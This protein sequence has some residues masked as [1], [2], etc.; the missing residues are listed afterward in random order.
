MH[1]QD[2]HSAVLKNSSEISEINR[3]LRMQQRALEAFK[4]VSVGSDELATSSVV[5]REQLCE[6]IEAQQARQKELYSELFDLRKKCNHE[7]VTS[8]D[9]GFFHQVCSVCNETKSH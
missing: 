7:F 9:G 3:S 6:Q 2:I 5:F 1:K 8:V 4:T